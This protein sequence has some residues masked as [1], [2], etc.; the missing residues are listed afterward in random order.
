MEGC[1]PRA[2]KCAQ[3]GVFSQKGSHMERKILRSLQF[4]ILVFQEHWVSEV[5]EQ[6]RIDSILRVL[7]TDPAVETGVP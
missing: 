5:Q 1:C 6:Q 3:R 2:A 4:S 7:G